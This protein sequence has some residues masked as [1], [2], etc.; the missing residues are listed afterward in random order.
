[1][2]LHPVKSSNIEQVGYDAKEK[3]LI[4]KFKKGTAYEYSNVPQSVYKNLMGAPSIGKQFIATVKG[5]F[6]YKI[7][8]I[9]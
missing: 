9:K 7:A 8:N 3:I 4:I 1:M 5:K 2:V 6:P